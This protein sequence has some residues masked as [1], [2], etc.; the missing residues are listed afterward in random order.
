MSVSS[1]HVRADDEPGLLPP[2]DGRREVD[3][4]ARAHRESTHR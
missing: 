1:D 2:P 3:S 4:A